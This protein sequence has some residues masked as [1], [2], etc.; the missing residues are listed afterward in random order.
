MSFWDTPAGRE[1]LA[2]WQMERADLRDAI[3]REWQPRCRCGE[4]AVARL[5][6]IWN[7]THREAAKTSPKCETHYR[8]SL[9]AW[10]RIRTPDLRV[11]VVAP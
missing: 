3:D 10:D 9:E 11:M 5:V 4:V 7:A 2:A 1:G 8:R 6:Y